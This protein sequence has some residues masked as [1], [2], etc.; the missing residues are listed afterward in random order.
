MA[1]MMQA[2]EKALELD[3]Q[4]EEA[5]DILKFPIDKLIVKKT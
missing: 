1:L 2:V 5:N 4:D 3:P